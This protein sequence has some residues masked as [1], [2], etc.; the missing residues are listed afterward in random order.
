MK[1]KSFILFACVLC[2]SLGTFAQSMG[3]ENYKSSSF[4]STQHKSGLLSASF[5]TDSSFIIEANVLMNVVADK[6]VAIFSL[7]QAGESLE[8]TN[9]LLAERLNG[10]MTDLARLGITSDKVYVDVI[11]Q[12]PVYEWQVEK[13]LFSKN[14]NEIP[15]GFQLQQNIHILIESESILPKILGLAA[16]FEIYDFVKTDY[17]VTNQQVVQDS[18][19]YHAT[20][21]INKKL[22]LYAKMGLK[23]KTKYQVIAESFGSI[24]PNERYS[25]YTAFSPAPQF[26]S[27]KVSE[28]T[29][30]QKNTTY[31][32]NRLRYNGY[33]MVL[34]P[35][36]LTPVVQF[37]LNL[38]LKYSI[39]KE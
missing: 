22:A 23:Y 29:M 27:K 39:K 31:Y 19:R 34:N 13:K 12:V 33:D 1:Y 15:S 2:S 8:T 30:N 32:Y 7:T 35:V 14:L 18:L 36:I 26:R 9:N 5:S 21:I 25:A 16:K 11:S 37:S 17:I 24:S 28:V 6:I 10:F 38:K 20:I 4:S 3:N